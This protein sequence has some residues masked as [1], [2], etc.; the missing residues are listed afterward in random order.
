LQPGFP[1]AGIAQLADIYGRH[2]LMCHIMWHNVK[3]LW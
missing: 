1:S 2:D 3:I